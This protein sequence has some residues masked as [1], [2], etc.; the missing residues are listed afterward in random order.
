MFIHFETSSCFFQ[1]PDVNMISGDKY[2]IVKFF[3][4]DSV[5]IPR[6]I[7]S[8]GKNPSILEIFCVNH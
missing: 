7:A 4:F 1:F 5:T 3:F 2:K 6:S 8:E